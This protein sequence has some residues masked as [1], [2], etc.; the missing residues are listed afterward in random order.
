MKPFVG[1]L[2]VVAVGRASVSPVASVGFA[3]AFPVV[4]K[5]AA[6]GSMISA[7]LPSNGA[8][9]VNLSLH[10]P[11]VPEVQDS[12]SYCH[13]DGESYEDASPD[14]CWSVYVYQCV[15]GVVLRDPSPSNLCVSVDIRETFYADL[16]GF[17]SALPEHVG[18]G[19]RHGFD[20]M[21]TAPL[22]LD[23]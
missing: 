9:A 10:L 11:M 20:S 2:F 6:V 18:H 13:H 22:P 1:F 17:F 16:L 5:F 7:R 23:E 12:K 14:G 3:V 4:V 21:F 8:V 15:G 19:I